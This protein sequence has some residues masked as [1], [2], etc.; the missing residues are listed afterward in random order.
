MQ[1]DV[2][3][4]GHLD[5]TLAKLPY[6]VGLI[7]RVGRRVAA[8][9]YGKEEISMQTRALLWMSALALMPALIVAQRAGTPRDFALRLEF[10]VCTSD[11]ADLF[12]QRY[13]RD[14]GSGKHASARLQLSEAE[15]HDLDRLVTGASFFDY[16]LQ[17]QTGEPGLVEPSFKMALRVRRNGAMH[18]VTWDDDRGSTAPEA[19]RLR[20][21]VMDIIAVLANVPAVKGLPRAELIC[22]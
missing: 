1:P 12:K 4:E 2:E 14:L 21:L 9:R 13:V 16:P 18:S 5:R 20:K 10:G 11:V 8:N 15:R 6:S 22:L 19:E 3:R 17:F 7:G